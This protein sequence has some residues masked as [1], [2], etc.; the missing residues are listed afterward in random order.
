MSSSFLYSE[1]KVDKENSPTKKEIKNQKK[2]FQKG[3]KGLGITFGSGSVQYRHSGSIYTKIE[4]YYILGVSGNYFL[5]NNLSVGLGYRGWFAGEPLIHQLDVPITYYIPIHDKFSPYIGALYRYTYV[6]SD[7]YDNYSSVGG[8]AG[9]AF[10]FKGG[11]AGVGWVQEYYLDNENTNSDT[12][13][14]PE[15]TIAI[16]F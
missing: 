12:F 5:V 8:R 13:G 1:D 14:Y 4:N 6:D 3:T 10:M 2:Y 7:I 15:V 16:S 11:Y 9:V